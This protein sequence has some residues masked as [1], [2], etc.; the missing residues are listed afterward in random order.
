MAAEWKATSSKQRVTRTK[1][2]LCFFTLSMLFL[3]LFRDYFFSVVIRVRAY[4][5]T[6]QKWVHVRVRVPRA[7]YLSTILIVSNHRSESCWSSALLYCRFYFGVNGSRSFSLTFVFQSAPSPSAI[8]L[9]KLLCLVG[10]SGKGIGWARL[11]TA[12]IAS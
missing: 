4:V 7:R 9:V 6:R 2:I 8:S 10:L 1:G 5:H 12:C 11:P 3:S